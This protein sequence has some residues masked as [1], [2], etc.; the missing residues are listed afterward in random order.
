M[1]GEGRAGYDHRAAPPNVR[2]GANNI[3]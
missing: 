2:H 3:N 1:A